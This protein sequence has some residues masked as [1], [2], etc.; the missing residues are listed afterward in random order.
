MPNATDM[1]SR[2]TLLSSCAL[3]TTVAEAR[4][5]ITVPAFARRDSR[6]IALDAPAAAIAAR[7]SGQD[8][9]GGR[10]LAFESA[11]PGD[12]LLRP[13]AGAGPVAGGTALL[14]EELADA[15]TVVMLA[16]ASPDTAGGSAAASVLGEACAARA[17]MT[18]ALVLPGAG[19]DE[20]VSEVVSALRPNAMVL[21]VLQDPRDI[22]GL[23]SALRV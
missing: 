7:L 22:P 5:R 20:E 17:I 9:N 6:V 11:L 4:Y 3:A 21:V 18:V 1:G 10:F 12:A 8:W 19:P 23:L 13:V 2:P 16:T 15:D 14:S